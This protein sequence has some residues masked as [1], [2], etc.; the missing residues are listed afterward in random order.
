[1]QVPGKDLSVAT[2]CNAYAGTA[3]FAPDVAALFAGAASSPAGGVAPAAAPAPAGPA[4]ATPLPVAVSADVLASYVGE[5][6]DA[7]GQPRVDVTLVDGALVVTP[8]GGA[9]FPGVAALGNGRF[10]TATP[11]V[12]AFSPGGA[13]G[14]TLTSI[15]ASTG[16]PGGPPL[17]R[18]RPM[19][20]APDALRAYA[21]KYEGDDL[22]L[23]L[24]VREH[25]GRLLLATRGMVEGELSPQDT[26]DAFRLP[27]VY[28]ARFERD[29]AGRV[30]AV[31]LD[32]SRVKG[33]R[34][35][36]R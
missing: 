10:A 25:A 3:S 6:R 28:T 31:V 7:G 35:T 24:H 2:L 9:P 29:A 11:F 30:V 26:P 19:R 17:Q 32:A 12:I 21:G 5:Y 1:V 14:M 36:R 22:E 13:D 33:M 4:A 16:E 15:E 34:F 8:R 23:V 27:E 20:A 18:W